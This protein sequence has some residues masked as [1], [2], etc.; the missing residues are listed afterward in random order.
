MTHP[1]GEPARLSA[2]QRARLPSDVD[3]ER[4]EAF[5]SLWP[6]AARAEYLALAMRAPGGAPSPAA[7]REPP[8][9]PER[10][11]WVEL[12]SHPRGMSFGNAELNAAW[13]A[14]FRRAV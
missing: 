2:E 4:L 6:A 5:L 8:S 3:P 11:V 12:L 1:V 10:V 13:Q 7:R 14:V 9:G